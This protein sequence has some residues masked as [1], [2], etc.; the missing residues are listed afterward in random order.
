MSNHPRGL[1]F[2]YEKICKLAALVFE[3]EVDD[4]DD[5]NYDYE[6]GYDYDY[7]SW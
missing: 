4:E 3:K 1:T 7:D 5:E 6:D 2:F